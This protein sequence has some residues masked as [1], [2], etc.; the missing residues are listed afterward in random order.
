MHDP[1]FGELLRVASIVVLAYAVYAALRELPSIGRRGVVVTGTPSNYTITFAG[2]LAERAVALLITDGAPNSDNCNDN[3]DD[4]NDLMVDHFTNTGIPFY[5]MGMDGVSAS[6]LD[7]LATDAGANDLVTVGG[8]STLSTASV[9]AVPT[10]FNA[11]DWSMSPWFAWYTLAS[12]AA[13]VWL[14]PASAAFF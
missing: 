14:T 3:R 7:Q 8:V 1:E 9:P 6:N 5:I 12:P 13:S 11:A 10:P 4:L 2:Q